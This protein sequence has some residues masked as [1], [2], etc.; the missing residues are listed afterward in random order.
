MEFQRLIVTNIDERATAHDLSDLF[1]FNSDEQ[2][3]KWCFVEVRQGD[4]NLKFARV[5]C[6]VE[7]QLEVLKLNGIEFFGRNLTI[8]NADTQEPDASTPPTQ[9]TST[10]STEETAEDQGEILWMLLDCRNHPEL[11]YPLV[12]EVEVCD[13]LMLD[14]ADDPHKAVRTLRGRNIG[15]FAIESM[16]MARYVEK[17][18]T[19]RG[20]EI[21]LQPIR[22]KA[23]NP[24]QQNDRSTKQRQRDPDSIKIR[25]FDAFRVQYRNISSTL[26]DEYFANMGVT[27]VI[28]T[29][30]ERC[31]E[32]RNFFNANRY[33]VV[34][35][36][37]DKGE[38]VNFGERIEVAGISFNLSYYNIQKYCYDCDRKHGYECP[39]K[40]RDA[41]LRE[42]RKGKTGQTKII[43]NS[44]MRYANPLAL[45]TNITC[46]SGAGIGQ[47]CNTIP[48]DKPHDEYIINGGTNELKTESLH[49]FVY[50]VHKAGEKLQQIV[51]AGKKVT[52]VLPQVATATPEAKAK[53]IY[54]QEQMQ[55]I[56]EIKTVCLSNIEYDDTDHPTVNGT[57]ELIKQIHSANNNDIIMDG[58]D[59]DT[60]SKRI[61]RKV[62]TA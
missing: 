17:T 54:L 56:T 34:K 30:P 19:I 1:G 3:R 12:Q 27:V 25:I 21:P 28:S 22:R 2:L 58:C 18:V 8:S 37:N 5:I 60:V 4:D 15:T 42:L 36:V 20:K 33:I 11:S 46:T 6:P 35:K 47:L 31:L 13:A 14:H 24:Q 7:Q 48:Y 44:N 61:Y 49:E 41:F 51:T 55:S 38:N 39:T 32:N 52:L 40:V 26:F 10:E 62:Q 53:S 43:S 16:D 50:T 45:R 59:D 57:R 23:R 29:R 9:Q